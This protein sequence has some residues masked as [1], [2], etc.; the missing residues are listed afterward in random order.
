MKYHHVCIQCGKTT[1]EEQTNIVITDIM[2]NEQRNKQVYCPECFKGLTK[3]TIAK[4]KNKNNNNTKSTKN[5]TT[6]GCCS[7]H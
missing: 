6:K 1:P 4:N 3:E 2:D 5:N 7:G